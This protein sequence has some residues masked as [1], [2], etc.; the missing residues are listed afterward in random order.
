[1]TPTLINPTLVC[2]HTPRDRARA[3]LKRRASALV[4]P[5]FAV[6]WFLIGGLASLHFCV[7]VAL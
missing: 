6:S 1:V 3:R 5:F 4:T 7:W 2:Y